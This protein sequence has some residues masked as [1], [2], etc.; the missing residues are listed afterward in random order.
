MKRKKRQKERNGYRGEAK[1]M[2]K[3]KIERKKNG[4]EV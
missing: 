4:E 3:D 1:E 2:E